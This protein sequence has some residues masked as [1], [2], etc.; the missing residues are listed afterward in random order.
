MSE[1]QKIKQFILKNFLFTE[2]GVLPDEESLVRKGVIDSTGVL[3]LIMFLE[4]NFG[5][6]IADEEM[7]PENLDSV[8]CIV[9]F[10]DR[11]RVAA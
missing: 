4:E 11:K 10:L 6:K 7:V 2:D 3:E 8:A 1:K 9:A 5:I